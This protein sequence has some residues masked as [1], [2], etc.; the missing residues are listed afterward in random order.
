ICVAHSLLQAW[1][2]VKFVRTSLETLGLKV[3]VGHDCLDETN[4]HTTE[5]RQL[6]R[7]GWF[8]ATLDRPATVFTFRLLKT[9]QELNFQGKT[10]LYD[11]WKS[12]ERI[13]DNSGGADVFNRYKQLSHAVRIW[14]HLLMLKRAGRGH[15][16]AGAAATGPGELVV[17]CPA[18]PHPGKNLPDDWES[19]PP[20]QKCDYH[21]RYWV[22]RLTY[23]VI[24]MADNTCSAEHKAI[25][26]A[27]LRKEG[28]IA[29]GI[30]AVLCARHA[31][32]RKNGVGDIQYGE[33]YANMDYL[34]FSTLI[35][36]ILALLISYDI[37]CQWCKNLFARMEQHFPPHMHIDRSK[38]KDIRFA[39][40][41]KH[42]RVHG[43]EP[44]SRWSLNLLRWV[45]R[46]YG[47]WIEAHW[48][49]MNP[50]ATST[51]E[52][53]PGMRHEVYNDHWGLVMLRALQE[54]CE[55]MDKQCKIHE[56][57]SAKFSDKTRASWEAM[58]DAWHADPSQP[59]PHE[60]PTTA[61]S[62]ASVKLALNEEEAI[63]AAA[64][65]LP[66][67]DVTPGVL[68]QVGLELEDR[69]RALRLR[70]VTG[71]SVSDLA[72]QQ[73]KRNVLM[74]CIELWQGIQDIHMPMVAALRAS[75]SDPSASDLDSP[76]APTKAENVKLWLPSALPEH[77]ASTETLSGLRQKEARLRLAQMADALAD[78]RRIRRV[79]AAISEFQKLN[80]HG[81]GQRA[82]T[83]NL[84][85]YDRFLTKQ[86][87]SVQRYRDARVAMQALEPHGNWLSTYKPLLDS[88]LRGPRRDEDDVITSEG[89]Y[90][91]SWIWL[92]PQS[93]RAPSDQARPATDEDARRSDV[94]ERLRRGLT[95][96]AEE[97]ANVFENL[98]ARTASFWVN[99]LKEIG[100][101]PEWI[102][103]YEKY[104]RKVRPP[105]R[106]GVMDS[107][108]DGGAEADG[109]SSDS[110][111]GGDDSDV[112]SM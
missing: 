84:G 109:S 37:A 19:A 22:Y 69:Q 8:P 14:R 72:E 44:H 55:F 82:V 112:D 6:I 35:G 23:H 96:Y 59:D 85:L 62:V 86:K 47:E 46:T 61:I 97:Q 42:F 90:E 63:E 36:L 54:A 102:K 75:A 5:W 13:T 95:I 52:M 87:R 18:C 49:H 15:N 107:A 88:D 78:I 24:Q 34:V 43:G 51:R 21:L 32:V 12:I 94:S 7:L 16:P 110:S 57:Y 79:L 64:G 58:L 1:D 108:A 70:S 9:F 89:R 103:P 53:G 91:I 98:A 31:L 81:T 101:L 10:N 28:Y 99:E 65:K 111:A 80:V 60:E 45:G 17:E 38:V 68:L 4:Q 29:S 33:K 41:K 27:N 92:T 77:M 105:R 100:P 50:L 56:E 106:G 11:Y 66:N 20:E 76:R 74:R 71:R 3:Q 39:I 104:A 48:S 83:R 73:Q 30:G 40:P 67:H 25:L 2:G 26:K 93:D